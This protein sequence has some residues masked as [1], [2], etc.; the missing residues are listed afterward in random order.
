[1]DHSGEGQRVG[2]AEGSKTWHD[3]PQEEKERMKLAGVEGG[4]HVFDNLPPATQEEIIE[5]NRT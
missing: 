1:M 4:S 5:K 3:A 2:A